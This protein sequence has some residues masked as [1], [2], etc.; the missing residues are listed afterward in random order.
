MDLASGYH[1]LR[2]KDYPQGGVVNSRNEEVKGSDVHKTA[3][4][5]QYG[6][7]EFLV[8][9]F[10]LTGAP[11][12]Y[13]RF[14]NS[15]LD[16]IRRPYIQV[17]LDDILIFSRNETEHIQHVQEVMRI[18]EENQLY[19]RSEKCKWMRTSLDYLGF[20][21]QG[22]TSDR[23]GGIT[24]SK[25]KIKAVTD[26]EIPTSVR[27]VQSFLGFVNFY[28]RFIS[29]FASTAA[30]LYAL[31]E[32]NTAFVWST[33]CTHAFR[34]LKLRL[35]TAPLLVSPRTG[36][37][38]S[39]II[40]TDASNKGLGAV[41]L[42]TQEDGSLRPCQYFARTLNRAQ[43]S[44]PI[45]DQEL[46]SIAAALI[47]FRPYIEGCKSFTVITDHRPLCHLPTQPKIGRRHVPW[48]ALLSQYMNYMTIVYR[49]GSENDSDPLSRRS[50][51]MDLT[52]ESIK[53]NP[54]L[55]RKF[56]EYDAGVF[57]KQIDELRVGISAMV[58]LQCDDALTK[59]IADGYQFDKA[60][61][62]ATV[63]PGVKQ[64]PATDL[65]WLADKIYVPNVSSI[66]TRIIAEFHATSGH[67]D[68]T[69]TAANILR[70]FY[71]PSVKKDTRSYI[72][73]CP[74]CQR[75]K[76]R[77]AKPFGSL[78]P[79]P[80]PTRPW[81]SVSLDLI[82]GLPN[83]DGYDAIVTFVCSLTKMAHFVPCASTVNARQ[84]ARLFLDNIYRL[85]GLPR[86]L[87]GDRDPRYTSHFFRS[88][89]TDLRTTLSL[90]TAYHPQTDGQT[91]RVHRT[92]EQ[93]LRSYVHTNHDQW[94]EHLSLAEFSYNNNV[95]SSTEY[96][97][98]MANCGFDPRT[99]MDLITPPFESSQG[100]D[101][102]LDKL[103]AIHRLIA[104]Q[105]KIA[106]EVQ[107]HY[108]DKRT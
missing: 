107:K 91:E 102:L 97:P 28:R 18:L 8:M 71:W 7:F 90:S 54:E 48:V 75:I 85:H 11:S 14:I 25:A 95:H 5:C 96:S 12:T 3:F 64:D 37:N 62:G 41:L 74:T 70:T 39:F 93:I 23:A 52:E 86:F 19:V 43:R 79:L 17:Y 57:E 27:D 45:Y 108:A 46:L 59:S 94:L 36:S 81:E 100:T 44:Y 58:H 9:P 15:I 16:P 47:E 49:K 53:D 101:H 106:K 104:D 1:Q 82:T 68:S 84:L 51:L 29:D 50:D 6:T 34:T 63:P 31:C 4:T 38:E 65:Y 92:I 78:M 13:Q 103:F 72:K 56:N 67:V 76:P 55:E 83:A 26:W 89:M 73:L 69:K 20:T 35:T 80:V 32:K 88:L 99:P 10:G 2:I 22:S 87:I 24:P 21:V 30:P 42:Q 105:L 33:E 60:F 77:P 40:S 98:F 66:K 61:S